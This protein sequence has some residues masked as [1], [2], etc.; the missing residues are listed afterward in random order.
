MNGYFNRSKGESDYTVNWIVMKIESVLATHNL[1]AE[2]FEIGFS[3]SKGNLI[4]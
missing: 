4:N 1:I 3:L 2:L